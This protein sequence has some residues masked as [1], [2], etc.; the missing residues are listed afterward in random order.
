MEMTKE[1]FVNVEYVAD[2]DENSYDNGNINED[3]TD[4]QKTGSQQTTSVSVNSENNINFQNEAVHPRNA[5]EVGT[6]HHSLTAAPQYAGKQNTALTFP[7][8]SLLL[9]LNSTINNF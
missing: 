6:T 3:S 9:K 7:F 4:P 2:N 1:V 8:N 5:E